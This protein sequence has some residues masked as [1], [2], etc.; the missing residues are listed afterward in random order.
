[1]PRL[2]VNGKPYEITAEPDTPLLWV[3]RAELKLTGTKYGCGVGVCGACTVHLD[4]VAARA[5]TTT[6]EEVLTA[7]QAVTTIEGLS[8]RE[9]DALRKAFVTIDV[10][11][12]GYCQSGQLMGA[13][14]LLKRSPRPTDAEINAA[15]QCNLCRCGTYPRIRAA[16]HQ[17]ATDM[18]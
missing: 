13:A 11:Q 16:I 1:M 10:V 4:G 3:L 9:A 12:C 14:A 5:C 18:R 6:V 2:L 17:A 8:G 7:R 15:M